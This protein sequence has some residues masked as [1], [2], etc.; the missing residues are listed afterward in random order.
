MNLNQH[1]AS[2]QALRFDEEH[3]VLRSEMPRG[4]VVGQTPYGYGIFTT[5]PFKEGETLYRGLCVPPTL[6]QLNPHSPQL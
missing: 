5:R 3:R 2:M 1:G 4:V 6:D